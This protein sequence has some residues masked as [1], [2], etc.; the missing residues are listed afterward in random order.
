MKLIENLLKITV[1][2]GGGGVGQGGA[3]RLSV[4]G[5]FFNVTLVSLLKVKICIYC[6]V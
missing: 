3:Y 2:A 6:S 4:C 1:L 5:Y